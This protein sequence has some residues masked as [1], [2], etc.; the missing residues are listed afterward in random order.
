MNVLVTAGPTKE[1]IDPVRF[2]SNSSSGR[3][4]VFIAEEASKRGHDVELVLGPSEMSP[5]VDV[6][7]QDVTTAEE[8]HEAVLDR[9]DNCDLLVMTAAVTDIRP[10]SSRSEKI[11]KRNLVDEFAVESTPDIL[12]ELGKQKGNRTL[13]GFAVESENLEENG[14][15]K[16]ER[17]N[18]DLIVLNRPEAMGAIDNRV[19][20]LKKGDSMESWPKMNKR[21]LAGKLVDRF[22]ELTTNPAK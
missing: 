9:F 14:R 20:L 16:L 2:I 17:K 7:V 1:P 3:M 19:H 13:V 8:M 15:R 10:S 5:D 4:G 11:N 22:L 21:T 12:E 18:L 6:E